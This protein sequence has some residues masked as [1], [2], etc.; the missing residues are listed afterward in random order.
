MERERQSQEG[1]PA[2]GIEPEDA[3][4]DEAP[5]SEGTGPSAPEP[6]RV[7]EEKGQDDERS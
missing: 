1:S 3:V 2:Q 7:I 5:P 6:D 4:P